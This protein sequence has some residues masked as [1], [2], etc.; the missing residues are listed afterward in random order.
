MK[1]HYIIIYL[2]AILH[3]P[4]GEPLPINTLMEKA[5]IGHEHKPGPGGPPPPEWRGDRP[6]IDMPIR[7]VYREEIGRPPNDFGRPPMRDMRHPPDRGMCL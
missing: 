6:P 2:Q 1:Q 4:R 5:G 3:Q 7:D